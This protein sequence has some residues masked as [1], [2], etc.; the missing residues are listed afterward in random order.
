MALDSPFNK[1]GF[2]RCNTF[3]IHN[4]HSS[5]TVMF[6][7]VGIINVRSIMMFL[8]G[9]WQ[10]IYMGWSW[11]S[12]TWMGQ[13][14]HKPA[15]NPYKLHSDLGLRWSHIVVHCKSILL[16]TNHLLSSTICDSFWWQNQQTCYQKHAQMK[17]HFWGSQTW[18]HL[19]VGF[20]QLSV[21]VLMEGWS[22]QLWMS[23]HLHQVL[24]LNTQYCCHLSNGRLI[25]VSQ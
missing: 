19:K 6:P 2:E 12:N 1:F 15:N 9:F 10:G 24:P 4:V 22:D 8:W 13:E 18:W 17:N 21:Q 14:M 20:D 23:C 7:K 3:L 5:F 25:V 16:Q 11:T